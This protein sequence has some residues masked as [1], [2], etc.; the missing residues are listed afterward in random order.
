MKHPI[1]ITASA[2]LALGAVSPAFATD[3]GQDGSAAVGALSQAVELA[4]SSGIKTAAAVSVAPAA[5]VAAGALSVALPAAAVGVVA[6]GAMG[7]SVKAADSAGPPARLRVSREVVVAQ[8]A[9]KVPYAAA[10]AQAGR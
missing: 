7:D 10:P 3:S 6:A 4:G 2:V 1:L 8:P 5:S 9:P